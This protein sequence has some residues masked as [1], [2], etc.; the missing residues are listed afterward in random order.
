MIP[1]VKIDGKSRHELPQLL[2]GLQ[3]IFITPEL[4]EAV[5]EILEK[6]IVG[7]KKKIGRLGMSLWELLVMG[8]VRLNLDMDYDSLY[9]LANHHEVLRGILGVHTRQVFGESKYY[10]IQTIKDN[11][12]LMDEQLLKEIS[13]VVVKAGHKLKKKEGSGAIELSLKTDTYAVESTIHFPTDLNLL[14]DSARKCM[15]TV[16]AILSDY[17]L[18]G[19]RKHKYW[20]K[21]IKK[22]YRNTANIHQKKG[23]DYQERLK[24]STEKYLSHSRDLS[25]M[26]EQSRKELALMLISLSDPVAASLLSDLTYYQ[27]MLDKHIG[28]VERRIIKGETIPHAEKIFSIFE[29]HTEWIQKGKHGKTVEL[30]H[31][32]LLT[33]D[34]FQFIVDHEV[35][36]GAGDKAQPIPLTERLKKRFAAGEY[37]LNSISFDRGFY[38]LLAKKALQKDFAEVIM[39]KNSKKTPQQEIEEATKTFVVLRKKHSAVESNINELEHGGVNRVPDKGLEGFKKYVAMGVLAYNLRRLGKM[40]MEKQLLL[41]I[42]MPGKLRMAA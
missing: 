10:P 4:N 38:S 30:G 7:D 36:V 20:Y 28:L 25:R 29:P 3:Y 40:V 14:W 21:T 27:Q 34:Q 16:E 37:A 8:T 12:A 41:T 9:D 5:F 13:E 39:P 1:D 15:D 18:E 26:V 24:E 11:V 19:W 17:S 22:D 32:A 6:K 35:L 42:V 31:N 2:A 33:T 23:K